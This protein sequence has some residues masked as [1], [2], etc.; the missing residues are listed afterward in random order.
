MTENIVMNSSE[1]QLIIEPSYG[2]SME[3]TFM[4]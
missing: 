4:I 3:T 2:M 1:V